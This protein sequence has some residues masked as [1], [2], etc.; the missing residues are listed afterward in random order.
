MAAPCA[1]EAEP[2]QGELAT[3]E[4]LA[5]VRHMLHGASVEETTEATGV[6]Q[7][8]VRGLYALHGLGGVKSC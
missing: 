4:R 8:A 1:V 3:W 7:D 2:P 5:I 6:S